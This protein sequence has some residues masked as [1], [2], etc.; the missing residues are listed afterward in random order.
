MGDGGRRDAA[1][2]LGEALVG[3]GGQAQLGRDARRSVCT[4]ISAAQVR[5]EVGEEA[6]DVAAGLGEAGGGAQG[7][8]RRW[9]G[10]TASTV[11]NSSSAS[12]APST[13]RTSSSV[14]AVPL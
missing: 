3:V 13:A 2:L 14:I 9:P 10:A 12:A 4:T 7:V 11:P 6:A 5:L 8:A 1:G